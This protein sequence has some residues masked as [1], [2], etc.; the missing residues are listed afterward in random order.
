[1]TIYTNIPLELVFEGMNEQRNAYMDIVIGDVRMQVEPLSPGVGR[2]VRLVECP[3]DAY[4]RPELSPGN[5][6]ALGPAV[7]K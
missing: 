1:M 6:I 3:L 4:L 2:I 7:I 5:V